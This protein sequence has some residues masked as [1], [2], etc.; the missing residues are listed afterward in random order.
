VIASERLSTTAVGTDGTT[1]PLAVA[2][3]LEPIEERL[4]EVALAQPGRLTLGTGMSGVLLAAARIM[5]VA[6]TPARAARVTRLAG[7][8]VGSISACP[9]R[10]GLWRGVVGVLYVMEYVRSIDPLL[11][12]EHRASIEDFVDEMD[13]MLVDSLAQQ[14]QEF[15]LIDGHCGVGAYALMRT[16]AAAARRLF[17][18]AEHALER[19]SELHGA[20]RT[21]RVP[22]RKTAPGTYDLGVAHGTPGVI[23]L[24]AHALRLDI[25]TER[26]ALLLDES[27]RWL[28][29]QE[30]RSLPHSRFASFA[31][32][33]GQSSRLGWCYGDVGVAAMLATV[34]TARQ[35]AATG[36]WWRELAGERIMRPPSTWV[37]VDDAICHGRAGVLH[38]LR[39]LIDQGWDA[40]HARALAAEL[41]RDLARTLAEPGPFESYG[42]IDGWAGVALVLAESVHRPQTGARPWHLCMLTPA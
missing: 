20:G 27:L 22:D 24:L 34:A 28:R 11:L 42:L 8:L 10:A 31:G 29:D 30:D 39:C 2:R 25:A 13:D 16:D 35:D 9:L 41:E 6:P 18:A 33:D 21:W 17:A 1:A 37:L 12:G 36:Q 15:D 40:P 23:G 3:L 14:S 4:A 7:A 19:A 5:Q 38:M 26:T 32:L